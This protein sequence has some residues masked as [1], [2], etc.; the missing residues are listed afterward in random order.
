[1]NI[2]YFQTDDPTTQQRHR[3]TSNR[4]QSGSFRS[5]PVEQT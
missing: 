2:I 5:D 3:N 4:V 1:M